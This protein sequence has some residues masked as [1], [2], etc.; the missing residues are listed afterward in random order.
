[1]NIGIVLLILVILLLVG[2]PNWPHTEVF[3]TYRNYPSVGLGTIVVIILILW[4]LGVF[5]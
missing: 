3:G 5:R 2:L 4:L 1:M